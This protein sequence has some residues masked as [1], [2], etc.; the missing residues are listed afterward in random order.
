MK[1]N[2]ILTTDS[3]LGIS[4]YNRMPWYFPEDLEFFNKNTLNNICIMGRTT[5]NELRSPLINRDNIVITSTDDLHQDFIVVRTFEEAL[6]K[7]KELKNWDKEIFVIGGS[8]L[9]NEALKS[10]KLDKIYYTHI[11]KSFSCDNF[12]DVILNRNDMKYTILN[13]KNVQS[14]DTINAV[15]LIGDVKLTFYLINK[16]I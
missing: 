3:N 6:K 13:T 16:I 2:I 12:V 11:N 15:N 14:T 9:F 4:R 7:A 8:R 5:A 10:D 1:F